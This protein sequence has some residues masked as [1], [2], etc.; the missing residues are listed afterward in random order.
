[1]KDFVTLATGAS[2]F[3]GKSG[4]NSL[5]GGIAVGGKAAIGAAVAYNDID[6]TF[7]A[8]IEGSTITSSTGPVMVNAGSNAVINSLAIGGAG[9]K[10]FA[11]GGSV[12]INSIANTIDAHV[13]TSTANAVGINVA[14]TDASTLRVFAGGIA[15]AGTAA[16]GAAVASNE[17]TNS[18]LASAVSSTLNAGAGSVTLDAVESSKVLAI[19]FGGAGA[20]T[21]AIGGS[22][23]LNDVS[24]TTRA[25]TMGGTLTAGDSVRIAAY[26]DAS[27]LVIGGGIAGA[28]TAAVGLGNATIITN[29]LVEALVGVNTTVNAKGNGSGLVIRDGGFDA[30]NQPTTVTLS[31]LGVVAVSTEDII[32]VAVGGAIAGTAGV[33]ASAA[34]LLLNETTRAHLD[35]GAKINQSNTGA[36]TNQD[37]QVIASDLTTAFGVGG[38]LG[39]GGTVG[40]GAGADIGLITKT[41][42]AFIM[43]RTLVTANSDVVVDA[44]SREDVSSI[45]ASL[46][47]GGSVGVGGAARSR[48]SGRTSSRVSPASCSCVASPASAS[49]A[50]SRSFVELTRVRKSTSSR[51]AL[52]N[53]R[54]TAHSWL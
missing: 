48:R 19:T 4:I 54:K 52:H 50:W 53:T 7:R 5:A 17:I 49:H 31:G 44:R 39:G 46:A 35:G 33:G 29:N 27:F 34:V 1:M 41:T 40:V 36:S 22:V 6:N 38:A 30:N 2:H 15:G 16:V 42:E 47:A 8:A 14:A 11:L 10:T 20:G 45:S 9:A 28:G 32:N 51:C 43:Q 18:T 3:L 26:D 24:N 23:S 13:S 25:F 21:V 37:V 12:S